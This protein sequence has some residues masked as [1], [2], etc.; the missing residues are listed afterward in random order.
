MRN[1]KNLL[2]VVFITGLLLPSCG[3][4][5]KKEEK[6]TEETVMADSLEKADVAEEV[7]DSTGKTIVIVRDT[8]VVTKYITVSDQ[9]K[10]EAK[11]IKDPLPSWRNTK[12]KNR[13]IEFVKVVTDKESPNYVPPA[14]RIATFDNDGTLWSEQ[15]IY[16]QL[17]FVFDRIKVLAP[18]HP[19]WKKDKLIQA[20]IDNDL[21]K[22]RKYGAEGLGKLMALTQAGMTTEEFDPIVQ[23]WFKTARH[24]ITGKK[25]SDMVFQPMLELINF[26][27][28]NDFKVYIVSGGGIDFMRPWTEKAYG[29][30]KEQVI[31]SRQKLEYT[32]VNGKP[33]LMKLTDIEFVD[34]AANKVI[35]IYQIIGK[36]PVLSFGNSD[37]DLQML[38][39]TWSGKGKR[40]SA[41]IHHTDAK[42]EWAYDRNSKVGTLDKGLDE[43]AEKGWLVVDMKKDWEV[44][45]PY[46]LKK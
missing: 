18:S 42:R 30:P 36:K 20:V 34:E 39:W 44:I 40:L 3:P 12:N 33:V 6:N 11:R 15:P 10:R 13:I 45:H 25:F 8:V 27:K 4:E 21:K 32:K 19:K 26:L 14:E 17:Y 29:I 43:A 1:L 22:V 41:Y 9:E 37:G 16:F 31:G 46:E 28:E 5:H 35:A 38:E 2:L 7:K 24:P 23:Q